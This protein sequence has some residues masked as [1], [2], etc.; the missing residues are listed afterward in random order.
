MYFRTRESYIPGSV[1]AVPSPP[2]VDC[3][4]PVILDDFDVPKYELKPKHYVPLQGVATFI[5]TVLATVGRVI[6]P[7]TAPRQI[8]GVLTAIEGHTDNSGAEKM[9]EGLSLSRAGA[10]RGQLREELRRLGIDLPERLFPLIARGETA[11]RAPNTTEAGRRQNRRV[12]IRVCTV[13]R[14][15]PTVTA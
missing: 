15:V 7:P 2:P 5:R 10:V 11:P 3:G 12:E 1:G 14:P 6:G 4:A 9:N 8:I 13:T